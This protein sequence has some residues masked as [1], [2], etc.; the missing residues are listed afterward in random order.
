M[1]ALK[2]PSLRF[3]EF[4]GEWENKELKDIVKINQGLQIP[5]SERFTEQ[6]DNSYFYI[7]NEFLKE[8]DQKRFFIKNPPQTVLCSNDDI[9][10]TRTGNTGKVVTNVSGAFHN[11]FFRIKYSKDVNKVFLVLFLM[12][13]KTQNTIMRLA[14][15]STIPDLNH[16]DFYKIPINTPTL[17][18]QTKLAAFLS[19][20]DSKIVQVGQQLEA[21]KQFKKGL[22][23][24]M[25][26]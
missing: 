16:G 22:L 3:P 18:E 20:I 8:G 25:F 11:N 2:V 21:A 13:T 4:S 7:T 19:A 26:V 15:I 6:V 12:L 24:Q 23:Q 14:G 10:M 9:L 5:I 17:P 1:N